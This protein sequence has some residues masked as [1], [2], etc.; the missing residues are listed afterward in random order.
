MTLLIAMRLVFHY[1]AGH[2]RCFAIQPECFKSKHFL[3]LATRT[4]LSRA[5]S[6][7][8]ANVM[9]VTADIVSAPSLESSAGDY[10][11]Q[12]LYARRHLVC[13]CAVVVIYLRANAH[14]R[15][16]SCSANRRRLWEMTLHPSFF[17]RLSSLHGYVLSSCE[18][19][20]RECSNKCRLF[21]GRSTTMIKGVLWLSDPTHSAP[22]LPD[23]K[24]CVCRFMCLF[25]R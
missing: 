17:V 6:F 1:P 7:A 25:G 3:V 14:N 24:L 23:N 2:R 21:R 20:T 15:T 18:A 4:T 13:R 8:S 16:A 19:W 10:Q 22:I 9:W 5:H 11:F 12:P